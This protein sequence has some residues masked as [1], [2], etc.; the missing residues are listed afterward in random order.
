[1]RELSAEA[2]NRRLLEA[3]MASIVTER[4]DDASSTR[5]MLEAVEEQ[6]HHLR[7]LVRRARPGDQDWQEQDT[8]TV[9]A[10]ANAAA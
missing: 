9:K 7:A 2:A 3:S 1:M 8:S 10:R 5:V 6:V 4:A